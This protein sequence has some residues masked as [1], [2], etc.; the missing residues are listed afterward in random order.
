[1]LLNVR[2]MR[3]LVE[4]AARNG[5]AVVVFPEQGISGF[6]FSTRGQVL[7]YLQDV[8]S[9][10]AVLCGDGGTDAGTA[11]MRNVSCLARE[12]GVWVVVG[13]AD[14]V[15]CRGAAGCPADGAYVFN[16]QVVFDGHGAAVSK[17]HKTHLF[18]GE[19]KFFDTPPAP[20]VRTFAGP[21]GLTYAQAICFDVCVVAGVGEGLGR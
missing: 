19:D 6:P 21:G 20:E 13:A 3:P 5:S 2:R 12:A 14:R 11:V 7:P 18:V 10:G 4:Q 17:Y 1:M 15:P 9:G 16:T 8:P